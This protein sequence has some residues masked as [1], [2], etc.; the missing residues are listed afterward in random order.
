MKHYSFNAPTPFEFELKELSEITQAKRQIS[1]VPHRTDFYQII[2][3]KSGESVQTVDFSPVK[4]VDGQ[5]LFLSKNQVVSFDTSTSYSGQ[6]ILFTDI[7]FNRCDCEIRLLKQ[8]NLFNPF[9]GNTPILA[10]QLLINLWTMMK[11][12]FHRQNDTFQHNLIHNYLSAFLIQAERQCDK[13]TVSAKNQDY[14]IALQFAE[15]VEQHYKNLRKVNDYLELMTVTAKPLSKALQATVGKTPKQF[16]DDRIL[17]EAKRLLVYSNDNIKEIT[18]TL[19]F[20]E[21]TNF[22]KFFREQTQL[23]PAEFK[24]QH[25]A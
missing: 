19:G 20:E 15:L 18:F 21:P 8:L 7:F 6:I 2:W 24:K 14:Q 10:N 5:I 13:T 25:T 4:V 9:T 1:C 17:L 12:E 23:S 22:S 16:I 11:D 3:V